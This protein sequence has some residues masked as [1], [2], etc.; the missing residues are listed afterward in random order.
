MVD[1]VR[2]TGGLELASRA[3]MGCLERHQR[4]F[5]EVALLVVRLRQ[6]RIRPSPFDFAIQSGCVV[7]P[8]RV[9]AS[10]TVRWSLATQATDAWTKLVVATVLPEGRATIPRLSLSLASEVLGWHLNWSEFVAKADAKAA[11]QIA[12]E[13]G[14][15]LTLRRGASVRGWLVE[16]STQPGWAVLGWVRWRSGTNLRAL[17]HS[18]WVSAG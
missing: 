18:G 1:F 5:S 12:P 11:E 8:K 3:A 17:D 16:L 4:H 6:W 9:A 14:W 7:P 15:Q 2:V 13:S 10:L